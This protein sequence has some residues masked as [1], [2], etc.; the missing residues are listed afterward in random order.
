MSVEL[1]LYLFEVLNDVDHVGSLCRV[2][3]PALNHYIYH[4]FGQVLR[5]PRHV[6]PHPLDY[7]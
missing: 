4:L 5:D 3:V 2:R 1:G 7:P 6:R